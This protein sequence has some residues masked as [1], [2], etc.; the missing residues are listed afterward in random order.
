MKLAP[1]ALLALS[2]CTAGTYDSAA[3]IPFHPGDSHLGLGLGTS[4]PGSM[5]VTGAVSMAL[6]RIRRSRY[7]RQ[8]LALAEVTLYD[9]YLVA[10]VQGTADPTDRDRVRVDIDGEVK[11][12]PVKGG[13]KDKAEL[14]D[15][16]EVAWDQV[17]AMAKAALE[18]LHLDHGAVSLATVSRARLGVRTLSFT[19]QCSNARHSGHVEYD[20]VGK[21]LSVNSQ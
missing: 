3:D 17:P 9:T 7:G 19:F 10:T 13:S 14:F 5:F 18:A 12:T 20:A 16:S 8:E 2:A 1:L 15:A 21:Q 4:G 11:T 6:D